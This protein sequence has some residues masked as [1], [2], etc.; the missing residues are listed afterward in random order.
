MGVR[1]RRERDAAPTP[2]RDAA[3]RCA[4]ARALRRAPAGRRRCGSVPNVYGVR[5]HAR[6]RL[7]VDARLQPR[8]RSTTTLAP[9]AAAPTHATGTCTAPSASIG[10]TDPSNYPAF[11]RYAVRAGLARAVLDLDRRLPLRRGGGLV[12]TTRRVPPSRGSRWS[13]WSRCWRSSTVGCASQ[14]APPPPRART[15]CPVDGD[16]ERFSVYDLD[17]SLARSVRRRALAR[18]LA[19]QAGADRDDLHA[20]HGDLPAR[21]RGAEADRRARP[22]RRDSCSCRSIPRATTR[23]ASPSTPRE[24]ALDP[25]RWTLLTGSDADVRDLAADAR[26]PL[27]ARHARGSRALQSHHPP[28]PRGARRTAVVR[29]DGRCRDRRAACDRPLIARCPR[30]TGRLDAPNQRTHVSPR[31]LD[32]ALARHRRADARLR[33]ADARADR[34]DNATGDGAL[35][36]DHRLGRGQVANGVG[37]ARWRGRRRR[38]HAAALAL[39][40]ARRSRPAASP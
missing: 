28:R 36:S 33:R 18:E 10:A 13:Y 39:R 7:G 26:R 9:S 38:V 23:I 3:F 12:I 4:T 22:R 14:A 40:R 11:L 32:P 27:P 17:G 6:R 2:A 16:A 29:T 30:R 25:S 31:P 5:A 24:R 20:L 1:R 8:R 19:R 34:R 35:P 37:R 15:V 21:G